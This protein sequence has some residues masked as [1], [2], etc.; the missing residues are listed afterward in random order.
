MSALGIDPN[1][2]ANTKAAIQSLR[3][4]GHII[5]L[6]DV[7]FYLDHHKTVS[8]IQR[9][10]LGIAKAIIEGEAGARHNSI[11]VAEGDERRGYVVLEEV[12]LNELCKELMKD[13]VEHSRLKDSCDRRGGWGDLMN[14]S[15]GTPF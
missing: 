12:F 2:D 6:S 9:V 14:P 11:F 3:N 15:R 8:G 7:F 5:D 4:P 10:Q 1:V 13:K